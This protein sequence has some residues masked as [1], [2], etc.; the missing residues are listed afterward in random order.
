MAIP[1]GTKFHGLAPKVD[2]QEKGSVL[3]NSARGVYTF[4]NEFD[5]ATYTYAA[6]IGNFG[7]VFPPFGGDTV[8]W[9]GL[10]FPQS[11]TSVLMFP[12][13]V[14]ISSVFF[15][16]CK[17][18]GGATADFLRESTPNVRRRKIC[19]PKKCGG[20]RDAKKQG[21]PKSSPPAEGP[22]QIPE[23]Y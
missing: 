11:Q 18:L 20:T 16:V 23:P 22:R 6:T 15:K 12:E 7:S 10:T 14:Q 1:N 17:P 8:E 19:G 21:R 5:L 9:S 4:P 13:T 3:A 2:T